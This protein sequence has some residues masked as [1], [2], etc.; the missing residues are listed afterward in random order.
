MMRGR[1][2][3]GSSPRRLRPAMHAMSRV[4]G[5][6]SSNDDRRTAGSRSRADCRRRGRVRSEG[7]A[8][9]QPRAAVGRA[10]GSERAPHHNRYAPGGSCRRVWRRGADADTGR[11]C[12]A[13]HPLHERARPR[14]GD[15]AG[16]RV[17]SHGA[18]A[19]DSRDPYQQLGGPRRARPDARR[20][21]ARRRLSDRRVRRRLRPRRAI[22]AQS[23]LRRL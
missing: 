12:G 2:C 20:T 16:P 23:R 1:I 19:A 15:A 21:P 17:D 7:S 4:F 22:R 10:A 13:R 9:S 8:A 14:A 6:C 3:S 18:A 11:S 5:G